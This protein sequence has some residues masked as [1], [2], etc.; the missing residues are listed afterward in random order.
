M[1]QR[2]DIVYDRLGV[3]GIKPG[4]KR[5]EHIKEMKKGHVEMLRLMTALEGRISKHE[6]KIAALERR[7]KKIDANLEKVRILLESGD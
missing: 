3:A 4:E 2:L 6:K 7:A 1:V 5:L